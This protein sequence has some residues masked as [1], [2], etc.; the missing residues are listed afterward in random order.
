VLLGGENKLDLFEK[1]LQ[2]N[3]ERQRIED[4]LPTKLLKA[5][6][7]TKLKAEMRSK[8]KKFG[9]AKWKPKVRNLV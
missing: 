2:K 8:K 9:K 6:A 7:R 3:T 5:C 1:I 4:D